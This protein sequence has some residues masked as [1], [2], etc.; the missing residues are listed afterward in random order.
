ML[1]SQLVALLLLVIFTDR[2][3]HTLLHLQL[4]LVVTALE[5]QIILFSNHSKLAL[6][7]LLVEAAN[8]FTVNSNCK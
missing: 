1:T 2:E 6:E 3:S 8:K 5:P 4:Q 7:R